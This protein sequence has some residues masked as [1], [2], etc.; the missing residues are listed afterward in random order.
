MLHSCPETSSLFLQN[1]EEGFRRNNSEGTG[2]PFAIGFET[3]FNGTV[4]NQL[5]KYFRLKYD[6]TTV[7]LCQRQ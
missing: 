4:S 5:Y 3:I 1:K 2:H 6:I 7:H